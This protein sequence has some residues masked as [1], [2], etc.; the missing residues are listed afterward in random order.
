MG[1]LLAALTMVAC[2]ASPPR[3]TQPGGTSRDEPVLHTSPLT[4][5]VPAAGLRWLVAG[6]PRQLARR[7]F[8]ADAVRPLFPRQRLDAYAAATGVDLR[9][10]PSALAAGF[11]YGT[12][13]MAATETEGQNEQVERLFTDRLASGPLVKQPHPRVRRI[14]G[15]VGRTPQALL[16]VRGALVAVAVGDTTQARIVQAFAQRKLKESPSALAGAALSVLPAELDAA[17]VRFYAPGP[18][19]GEWLRGARGLLAATTALGLAVYPQ[20]PGRLEVVLA[21]A[22]NWQTG[23]EDVTARLTQAWE[24]LAHSSTG[25]LLGLHRPATAPTVSATSESLELR[26]ELE[27]EPIVAGLRAA[28]I[29]DVWEILDLAPPKAKSSPLRSTE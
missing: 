26:T 12:L 23:R 27:I 1:A 21:L 6:R 28:V 20:R 18:F 8:L 16:S 15:V 25:R 5:L 19:Q 22:G 3:L 2:G 4:D 7:P 17:P 10:T 24:D 9:Q 13:Y 29:A 14:V 11:D